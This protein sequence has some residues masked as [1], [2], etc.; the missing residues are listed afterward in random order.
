[1]QPA[2]MSRD[3]FPDQPLADRLIEMAWLVGLIAVPVLFTPR[4]ILTYHNDPKYFV[5]HLVA[6]II[7]IAWAFEW[8][9][10][11]SESGHWR[12]RSPWRWAGRRPER[13]AVIAGALLAISVVVST[14]ASP[15]PRVSLWGRDY[16]GLGYEM[17]SFL[18]LL[19]VF[20][21][22][23]LRLRTLQQLS[24][25]FTTLMIAGAITAL[26][27]LSQHLGWDPL[28]PGEEFARNISSLGNPIFFGSFILMAIIATIAVALEARRSGRNVAFGVSV[29]V[30]G[31]E[32]AGLWT[33]ESRGPLLGT[34]VGL[35]AFGV[36][37]GLWLGRRTFLTG[38][39]VMAVG[40]IVAIP[41][42]Q[43]PAGDQPAVSR[44]L[45][46]LGD[47][48]DAEQSTSIGGRA[49]TWEGAL[50]LVT[51]WERWPEESAAQRALR[52][53]VGLGPDMYFYSYPLSLDNDPS[54]AGLFF[55]HVHNFLMQILLEMGFLGLGSFLALA[56]LVAYAAVVVLRA[57]KRAGRSNGLLA[58][59]V[60][61]LLATLIGR[62]V[63]Q[64]SGVAHVSDLITFWV[65]A[66]AVVA[67]AGISARAQQGGEPVTPRAARPV[68]KR[69][70]Y[71]PKIAMGVAILILVL[72]IAIFFMRDVRG[73]GAS[74]VAAQGFQLIKDGQSQAGLAKYEQAADLNPEIELYVL[75]LDFMIRNEAD[76][77][78]DP[79]EKIAL[80][81]ISLEV[82]E[83]YEDRDPFAH[84]TQRRI[85]KTELAL[86]RLGQTERFESAAE[87]YAKLADEMRSFPTMQA[88][89]SEGIV[90][91]GDGMR[92]AGDMDTARSFFE[93]GLFYAD[94]AIAL[95][96]GLVRAR[97]VRGEALERLGLLDDAIASY[98][99]SLPITANTIYES[100]THSGL[101]RAY[102]GLGDTANADKHRQ[103]AEETDDSGG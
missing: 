79:A 23:A 77:R 83:K 75:Q 15:A 73:I 76:I 91:A 9:T 90:A 103:L 78:E 99:E 101:A 96:E 69:D 95:Y 88:L 93:S 16:L 46:D 36:I 28:G 20:F 86:G 7:V 84:A 80:N 61:V 21:A 22:V 3:S 82:L 33:S 5:V 12:L 51:T 71:G 4:R 57:E 42:V 52:P 26:Y 37:S 97:W 94:R 39:A 62:G 2:E 98:L 27:A 38:L 65:L 102:E 17:Y 11:R 6:V 32:L 34:A 24:R 29:V 60:A 64:M 56:L 87:R 100:K 68:I 44:N 18:A 81:E 70:E 45:E 54:R 14:A 67:L 19:V 13:W 25:I 50:K 10:S 40:L 41:I 35:L 47:I 72:G 92:S 43:L 63:E 8:A 30:L 59:F 31:V 1:M 53:I 55:A 58:I 49:T 85:A 74:R 66:G 48:F 89:A